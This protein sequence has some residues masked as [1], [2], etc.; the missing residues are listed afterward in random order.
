VLAVALLLAS[1]ALCSLCGVGSDCPVNSSSYLN[2]VVAHTALGS[3]PNLFLGITRT[4]HPSHSHLDKNG[5][6]SKRLEASE[7]KLS[8]FKGR[9]AKLN[10][11]ILLTLF[12]SGPL[13]IY[14]IAKEIR[15]WRN[16]R[17]TKYSIVNRRVRALL[18]QG[19]LETV[20]IRETKSG[21]WGKL[22]Q[23]TVR[24][25]V[26][27]YLSRIGPDRFVKEANDEA[28]T[29]ELAALALFLEKDRS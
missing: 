21:F 19:Y 16:F 12:Q 9:E 27:F 13:V 28:L 7:L 2:G 11:A 3:F 14:D 25:K 24:A 20:G 10:R 17:K 5:V 29:T 4:D 15:K 18:E 26:A 8:V 1:L 22:Y 6:H 23:P